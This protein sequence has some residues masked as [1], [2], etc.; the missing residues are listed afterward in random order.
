MAAPDRDTAMKEFE[1]ARAAF[2]DAYA[3]VPDEALAFLKPGE[4]YALGGLVTHVVAIIEHYQ[5]VLSAVLDAEFGEGRPEDAPGFWGQ[6]GLAAH[7]G[8]RPHER[9]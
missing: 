5:L 2:L 4:D 6:Q 3:G 7:A 9:E 8:A 1:A